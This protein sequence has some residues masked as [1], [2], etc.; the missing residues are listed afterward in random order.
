MTIK[1]T[2]WGVVFFIMGLFLSMGSGSYAQDSPMMPPELAGKKRP[3]LDCHRYPNVQT[4]AGAYAS[5]TFC[6]ECHKEPSCTK[7][8]GKQTV[9]L[10]VDPESVLKGR[11]RY[12]ACI[13]CHIDVARSPH[14][15][16]TGP[17]CLGCHPVHGEGGDIR[18]PHLRVQCQACHSVY[19]QVESDSKTAQ[20]VLAHVNKKGDPIGLTDHRLSDV[21]TS[22]VCRRCHAPG[23]TV[24]AP[25]QVLPSKSL[26]CILCHDAPLSMGNPIFWIAFVI[27]IIGILLTIR[28]WFQGKVDGESD[29]LHKKIS[30]TSES[31]WRTLFSK[32]FFTILKTLMFDVVL[33]RRLLQESVRRWAIHSLIYLS[34]LFRLV[35]SIFTFFAYEI[36]PQSTLAMALINKNNG[37][38]AFV[39]DLT[40]IFIILGVL[41]ALVQRVIIKPPHAA[42]EIKD[43]LALAIIGVLVVLGFFLEGAR[44]LMT[45]IPAHVSLYA[46]IGYPV[47]KFLSLFGGNWTQV[48]PYLWYAHAGVGA[49]LVAYLPFGK[50]RHIFNTP[51][52]LLLNYKLK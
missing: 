33:Q 45:G 14:Y 50:M 49:L 18:A 26:I 12:V 40:G 7:R 43:N 6:L 19:T 30:L 31:I 36:S 13:Q 42:S 34:I 47:S 20:I 3:C 8:A 25:T 51:L 41:W 2:T 27:F 17:R 1:G 9:S 44:I 35:L 32:D 11:H 5:Q 46:F 10:K 15:S 29:S 22:D 48:Y 38:I 28:F 24:G 37:F 4:D 16:E 23:N 52:T 39:N 21:T